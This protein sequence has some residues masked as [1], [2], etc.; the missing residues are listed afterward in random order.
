LAEHAREASIALTPNP[1]SSYAAQNFVGG[2]FARWGRG[3]LTETAVLLT[4]EVVTNAIVHART[5]LVVTAT[6]DGNRARVAVRDEV[7]PPDWRHPRTESEDGRGLLLVD[8]LATSWGVLAYG[9]G[10]GVWFEL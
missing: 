6:L 5:D 9:R 3:E 8:A 7:T 1:T 2:N 10:K 4:S